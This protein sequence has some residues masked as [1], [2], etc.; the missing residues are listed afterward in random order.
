MRKHF[1]ASLSS[2]DAILSVLEFWN[3]FALLEVDGITRVREHAVTAVT[4]SKEEVA[5]GELLTFFGVDGELP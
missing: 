1:I 5:D 4:N 2:F 3:A